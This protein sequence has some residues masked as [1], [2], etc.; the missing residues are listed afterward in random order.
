MIQAGVPQ[1]AIIRLVNETWDRLKTERTIKETDAWSESWLA[2]I[3]KFGKAW[4]KIS[5]SRSQRYHPVVR[6]A[7]LAVT[8]QDVQGVMPHD[9]WF[10]YQGRTPDDDTGSDIMTAIVKWGHQMSDFRNEY[11]KFALMG[12][13]FGFVP[14]RVAW[15]KNYIYTPDYD[16]YFKSHMENFL[17]E[18]A[19]MQMPPQKKQMKLQGPRLQVGNP[20][21]YVQ[22]RQDGWN[23]YALR[24]VKYG[25]PASWVKQMGEPDE[26]GWSEFSNVE[27]INETTPYRDMSDTIIQGIDNL[28]GFM[29]LKKDE[30]SIKEA[31]GDFI[32]PGVDGGKEVYRNYKAVI[33]NGN[34]LLQFIPNPYKHGMPSWD[35]YGAAQDPIEFY[36]EGI[37]EPILG[38]NDAVQVTFNQFIENNAL[39]LNR[40]FKYRHDGRFDPN[41]FKTM[42]GGL[43]EVAD[44]NNLVP[45]WDTSIN[46]TALQQIGYLTSQINEITGAQKA[47]TS[48]N[49]QKSATEVSA[50]QGMNNTSAAEKI[51]HMEN[52]ALLKILQMEASLWQQFMPEELVIRITQPAGAQGL[53]DPRTG[54]PATGPVTLKA[55]YDDIAGEFDAVAVGASWLASTQQMLG[56]RTQYLQMASQNPQMNSLIKWDEVLRAD[57]A[58]LGDRDAYRFIKT[59]QEVQIEQQQQQQQLAQQSAQNGMA[60]AGPGSASGGPQGSSGGGGP[61]SYAGSSNVGASANA[62]VAPEQLQARQMGS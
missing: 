19:A 43:V 46:T 36:S 61:V 10:R 23:R 59:A 51:R 16:A 3:C 56:Q 8:A 11:T 5:K 41:K 15:D 53:V 39:F 13:I 9:D 29:D 60:N 38:L 24:I 37:V 2:F 42:A 49:Y 30:V 35:A 26:E 45:L 25:R 58:R 32:V 27:N 21:N 22:D 55:T 28:L 47:F 52:Q 48:E 40:M 57:F 31:H 20:F 17:G 33:A 50:I 1:E 62:G 7:V 18:G 54:M 44:M 6:E 12:N 34:T 14:Y 4:S